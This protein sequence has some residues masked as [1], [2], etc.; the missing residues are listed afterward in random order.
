MTLR[1]IWQRVQVINS[2]STTTTTAKCS[3]THM[4]ILAWA[5]AALLSLVHMADHNIINFVDTVN[6]DMVLATVFTLVV[7]VDTEIKEITLVEPAVVNLAQI[8]QLSTKMK[9]NFAAV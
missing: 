2:S 9:C 1:V 4:V 3:S 7:V 5:V 8:K 6:M